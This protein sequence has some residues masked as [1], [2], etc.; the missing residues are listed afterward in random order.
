MGHVQSKRELSFDWKG[1]LL[2]PFTWGMG[3]KDE[4]EGACTRAHD[5]ERVGEIEGER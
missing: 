1:A 5:K 3:M 2:N 4:R